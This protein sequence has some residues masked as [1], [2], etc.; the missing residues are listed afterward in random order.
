MTFL[1][2]ML[3]KT[4]STIYGVVGEEVDILISMM[5]MET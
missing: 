3:R 2:Y 4:V 5:L 1:G